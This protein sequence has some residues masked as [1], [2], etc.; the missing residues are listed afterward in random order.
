MW[1]Q[2]SR[3]MRMLPNER[4]TPTYVG[5]TFAAMWTRLCEKEHPHV[6]GDNGNAGF[7]RAF[8]EGTP[9]RMWGQ[10]DITE[11]KTRYRRNTPTYV[12]TTQRLLQN[13][14]RPSEHPHVCGDNAL[15]ALPPPA[16]GGTP[17][18]M[19]G[20]LFPTLAYSAGLRNTPTYVGT[21]PQGFA[22]HA[23]SP[24]HPHVC[25]DNGPGTGQRDSRQG[26]PPRMWGQPGGVS[27]D[28]ANVRNTPTYVGT[29]T[30]WT[31][32]DTGSGGTPPRMWGQRAGN[33]S[34]RFSSR[35]TPTYV[36]TTR[37]GQRRCR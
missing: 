33:W 34:T 2:L 9:P 18:R 37:W 12:G 13:P 19:W 3:G 20:Q 31:K 15:Y 6:C 22:V 10:L 32:M 29:T 7:F 5:T 25:G 30:L 4:N 14:Q 11:L 26:T 8:D 24:E 28:A 27:V 1:G 21:T 36:G 35:N 17:P 23:L 16:G